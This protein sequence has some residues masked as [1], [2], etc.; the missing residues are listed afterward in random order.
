MLIYHPAFDLYNCI[1]RMLQLLTFMKE[2]EIEVDR[3]RLWD[4]YLTF[5]GEIRKIQFPRELLDL[6]KVFKERTPN[7]YEDLLDSKKI[8]ERMKP[9]QLTALKSIA[10][11]EFIGSEDLTRG[12]VK[13]VAMEKIPQELKALLTPDQSDIEKLNV[14][15]LVTGFRDLPL[16]GATGLKARTG[17]IE[18]N[19]DP[20]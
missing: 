12:V 13:K 7:P 14:L 9:Y 5:P 2:D 19:Y 6:R 8:I 16:F 1:F 4:F 11:Y 20:R 10:S 3:L 15:K 18:F 17:L